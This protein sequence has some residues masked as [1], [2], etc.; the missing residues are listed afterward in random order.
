MSTTDDLLFEQSYLNG[1]SRV[2][3]LRDSPEVTEL[4]LPAVLV[5]AAYGY[6]RHSQH[7]PLNAVLFAFFATQYPLVS[8]MIVA[9]DAVF[10]NN[11]PAAKAARELY[12]KHSPS[13]RGKLGF[14]GISTGRRCRNGYRR[15]N[16]LCRRTR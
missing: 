3:G 12:A 2:G 13:L 5:S 15:R 7:S 10:L 8:A 6:T 14:S 9:V 11:T 1:L 4:N 16:G